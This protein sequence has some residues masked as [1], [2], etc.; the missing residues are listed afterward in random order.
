MALLVSSTALA[1]YTAWT[2]THPVRLEASVEIAAEPE[3]V[4]DV[5][6]D[7][8]AY[9]R[10]NPFLQE[11]E[12]TSAGA[13][14]RPG[15]TLRNRMVDAGGASTFTPTVQVV[16]PDRELRWLG[17]V[18]PGWLADGEHRFLIEPTG[19][20]TVRLIQSER[21][22]GVLIPFVEGYLKDNTLPQFHA[23]NQA[24]KERAEH[25]ATRADDS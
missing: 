16:E 19:H 9:P 7:F 10:W 13:E 24:L 11:A 21:F 5:L 15:A 25:L 20:G 3:Q 14:L 1:G 4:W 18:G 6:T 8:D 22:T 12:V 23:M 2:H 17:K